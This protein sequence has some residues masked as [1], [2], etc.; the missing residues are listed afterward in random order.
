MRARFPVLCTAFL[1][2]A[3]PA[4][5][6][7][8]V[9]ASDRAAVIEVRTAALIMSGQEGGTLPIAVGAL[10]LPGSAATAVVEID[11]PAL[12]KS[13]GGGAMAVEVFAYLLGDDLEVLAQRSVSVDV[14][15]AVHGDLLAEAGLKVF[16]PLPLPAGDV[17]L[18]VLARAG[19]SFGLRGMKL[20]GAVPAD[21][22]RMLG[23]IF[24]EPHR[25]WLLATSGEVD[26]PPPFGLSG[27]AP[28]P[29]ALPLLAAGEPVS[30]EVFLIG[31]PPGSWSLRVEVRD[32]EDTVTETPA[33]IVD[34]GS[35]TAGFE[36]LT[37]SF[38]APAAD[39]RYQVAVVLTPGEEGP[40][41]RLAS[42]G[43]V[44]IAIESASAGS[45][46]AGTP[47][48]AEAAPLDRAKRKLALAAREGYR[49]AL[50]RLAA[51]DRPGA[52]AALATA[53]A[54]VV[55]AAGVE[56]IVILEA[57]E[58][59]V[60][61][62][63]ADADWRCV[64]P[65]ILLHVDAGRQYRAERRYILAHHATQMAVHLAD[66]YA[67]KLGT[68]EAAGE[69]ARALSSLAGYL[70]TGGALSQAEGLFDHALSLAGDP[71]AGVPA[72]GAP[73]AQ[74]G[75]ATILEKRGRFGQAL[76]PLEGFVAALPE[77]SEGRLRLAINLARTGQASAAR[78]FLERL[79]G[80]RREA[81][82]ELLACQELARLEM[83][84]GHLDRAAAVLRRGLERWP[85]HPTL[86]LQLA[87]VLEAG[88]DRLAS[89]RLLEELD[90][91]DAAHPA[92][93]RSR[94]NRWP[95]D[96]LRASRRAL[97]E[98]ARG[99]LGDLGRWLDSLPAADAG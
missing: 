61:E 35:R 71:A 18:R 32:P 68:P 44:P 49:E 84:Q 87:Y 66:A 86:T 58:S 17:L 70:Q 3:T 73:A 7:H 25:P 40:A 92:T 27:G 28:L 79:A 19:E 80:E 24:R 56:A 52:L 20:P 34:R 4:T 74:L 42:T 55:E 36:T 1:T 38:A 62:P 83:D 90:L 26:L 91:T 51:G 45:V 12:L 23:P 54:R 30:A 69:A 6:E 76:A 78:E 89:R 11:G 50:R 5:A 72:A 46:R 60:L 31:A 85:D 10:P 88:G 53:E 75:I 41:E 67:R 77:H 82:I 21:G 22:R 97:A 29:T 47:A 14:D 57:S 15:P 95:R 8:V 9:V 39:G 16:L 33:E 98:A 65:V 48:P 43:F 81:W 64:L 93:E 2:A 13:A 99:R 59:R 37:V 63:L 94:Y 96:V